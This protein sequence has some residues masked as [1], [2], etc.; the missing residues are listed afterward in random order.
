M[1]KLEFNHEFLETPIDTLNVIGAGGI[2]QGT[3]TEIYGANHS[4]KSAFAYQTAGIFLKN[5]PYGFV[6]ILDCESSV[7][8]VRFK[9]TFEI[10]MSRMVV[11]GEDPS[12]EGC[13]ET[14]AEII[15]S[16]DAQM[17]SKVTIEEAENFDLPE[18]QKLATKLKVEIKYP[19]GTTA[20]SG[21]EKTKRELLLELVY[22][23]HIK[24]K[25][26]LTPHLIIWDTIASSRP[27]ASLQALI[28]D[29]KSDLNAGG[30]MMKP[31]IIT[32]GLNMIQT[33]CFNKPITI[34]LLNQVSLSGFGT[35]TGP[36][37]GSSGGN[38]L[39]HVAHY[40]LYFQ[41]SKAHM[42]ANGKDTVG[43]GVTVT[44]EKSKFS[45]KVNKI[46]LYIDDTCGGKII[47]RFELP[48]LCKELEIIKTAGG[49]LH[50]SD[51]TKKLGKNYRWTDMEYN[52]EVRSI[53]KEM[54]ANYYRSRFK[55]LDETFKLIENTL[56]DKD[57]FSRVFDKIQVQEDSSDNEDPDAVTESDL[58][59]IDNEA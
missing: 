44:L 5:N 41:K 35:F 40:R 10:D 33:S 17:I 55:T 9:H 45:P 7:D 57:T 14:I 43:T 27:R 12:L 24:P 51:G 29:G 6:T 20:S 8:Y 59:D 31:R 54:V 11:R 2:N 22:A 34:F 18:L 19:V 50:F 15:R 32:N 56:G 3:I 1:R 53:C 46:H 16:V 4:G 49:W 48:L 25:N 23:G 30:M 47:P 36:K 21:K 42:S 39:K 37:E 58:I 52:E 13:M 26:G 38:A 28:N